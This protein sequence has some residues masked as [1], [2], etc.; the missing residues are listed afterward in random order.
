MFQN[1]KDFILIFNF[2]FCTFAIYYYCICVGDCKIIVFVFC[3]FCQVPPLAQFFSS[4]L[5]YYNMPFIER[6]AFG[7]ALESMGDCIGLGA[8]AHI[9]TQKAGVR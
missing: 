3:F 2:L 5:I 1:K 7:K 4:W 8:I 9:K 6:T